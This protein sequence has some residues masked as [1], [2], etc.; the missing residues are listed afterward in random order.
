MQCCTTDFSIS[1]F[2]LGFLK[3][4]E[5]S[6]LSNGFFLTAEVA[7]RYNLQPLLSSESTM[8]CPSV[9]SCIKITTGMAI[10]KMLATCVMQWR[11]DSVSEKA[12][13]LG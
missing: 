8:E 5:A 12:E 6:A 7:Y 1:M 2:L 3:H 9:N 11:S 13:K 10:N 4:I